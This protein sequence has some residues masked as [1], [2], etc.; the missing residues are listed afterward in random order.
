[1]CMWYMYLFVIIILY[2]YIHVLSFFLRAWMASKDLLPFDKYRQKFRKCAQRTGFNEALW[3]AEE[4]PL[5]E[6][7][8]A[9][10]ILQKLE[11]VGRKVNTV[12]VT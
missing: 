6:T 4:D 12:H 5:L 10:P 8:D 2:V 3:E 7:S 11:Q 1:M 9:K